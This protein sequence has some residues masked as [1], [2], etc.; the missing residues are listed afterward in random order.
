MGLDQSIVVVNEF[1][2]KTPDGGT[3]GGTPGDYVLR[4]MAREGASEA[5]GP[6]LRQDMD[7]YVTKYMAREGAAEAAFPRDKTYREVKRAGGLGGMAFSQDLLSLSESDL[8]ERS[9]EI[10]QAFDSG[11]TVLKTVLSFDT[12]YLER[13]G[14]LPEGFCDDNP[15][16]SSGYLRGHVD[17]LRLR[18]AIREGL[19]RVSSDYDDLRYVGVIQV[20]TRHVHCHLALVDMGR[21]TVMS[22]GTQRGKLSAAQKDEIRR[23]VDLS[24]DRDRQVQHMASISFL[25]QRSVRTALSRYAY[26]QVVL[27]GAPQRLLSALPEDDRL[28]RAGSFRKD[29][30]EA[31]GICRGYVE[32]VLRRGG[33]PARRAREA[34]RDYAKIRGE[35]EGLSGSEITKIENDARD[36]MVRSCM[37]GVYSQLRAIPAG[38]RHEP[39]ELLALAS[40]PDISLG[41]RGD[42][43][44][45]IYRMGAYGERLRR[46]R[47][48]AS[49][50][51][52]FC[53]EYETA[54]DAGNT[55][56]GSEALYR[57][58]QIER[59][60]HGMVSE[61]YVRFLFFQ[62]PADDLI[63]DFL[64]LEEEAKKVDG[65]RRLSEDESLG[66]LS[67]DEAERRG[68]E[69]YGA[70]GGYLAVL[71]PE[72]LSARS[73]RLFGKYEADRDAFDER[74]RTRGLIVEPDENGLPVFRQARRYS[75]DDIRA[76]DLHDLRGDFQGALSF[77]GKA[78]E[79]FL[80]MAHQRI[81]TF[82]AAARYLRST[83]QAELVHDLDEED[84]ESAR[85]VMWLIEAGMP[86]PPVFIA[87]K[88]PERKKTLRLD[89]RLHEALSAGIA[90]QAASEAAKMAKEPDGQRQAGG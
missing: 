53:R 38:R 26:G 48:G 20:D 45:M 90:Q 47:K 4:Y 61:K 25:E 64:R 77:D 63:E 36:R 30:K 6:A 11:K 62:P 85:H 7:S 79:D 41:F 2:L 18:Q 35:R 37:D 29:M 81:D 43:R 42:A 78:R 59:A 39:T 60:Y 72:A 27:Y 28:W 1:S 22:D 65:L 66:R 75:F 58:F 14:V 16:P 49:R 31:N 5:H 17:Q 34:I 80:R 57:F 12:E 68:R 88:E 9:R 21:G 73:R 13:M 32:T 82:D 74:L 52:R 71:D 24:L 10:Q 40:D 46:H 70:Y 89:A 69:L 55:A 83:G 33:E 51:D 8:R 50:M 84:I 15:K 3:R 19:S 23:G 44:D 67:P 87:P 76:L 86:V 54:K 56:E